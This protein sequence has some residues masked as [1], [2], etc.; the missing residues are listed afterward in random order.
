MVELVVESLVIG[1]G[2]PDVDERAAR[3]CRRRLGNEL[4]H[5]MDL[6]LATLGIGS[7]GRADRAAGGQLRG[8]IPTQ[9]GKEVVDRVIKSGA[10]PACNGNNILDWCKRRTTGSE[11]L[12]AGRDARQFLF[13]STSQRQ[14]V[15]LDRRV[16]AVRAQVSEVGRAPRCCG[17]RRCRSSR[18]PDGET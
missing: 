1:T 12:F 7:E 11:T 8:D 15:I 17:S 4:C 18:C 6:R 9:L 3:C 2:H 13:H 5:R 16:H 14:Q 10:L